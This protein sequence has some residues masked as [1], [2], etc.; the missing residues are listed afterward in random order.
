MGVVKIL[1]SLAGWMNPRIRHVE[2]DLP[3]AIPARPE[4][5]GRLYG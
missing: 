4:A 5:L 1:V 3:D 2:D